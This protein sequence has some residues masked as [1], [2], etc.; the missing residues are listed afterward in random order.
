MANIKI[1]G[2]PLVGSVAA[3]DEYEINQAGTSYK[4]TLSQIRTFVL[5]SAG[6]VTSVA[7]SLPGIFSVSGSPVTT[8]GTLSATLVSQSQNLVFASPNGSAGA[9]TFRSLVSAD[10]PS[11]SSLYAN[12][13]LS[14]LTSPTAI[15]QD[16]LSAVSNTYN[17]GSTVNLWA[18][19]YGTTIVAGN[20][21]LN[22]NGSKTTPSGATSVPSLF[23]V[24]QN[25]KL[26]V[27]SASDANADTIQTGNLYLNTGN[28]TAGTG[29]SGDIEI[30][31]GTSAGGTRGKIRKKDGSEGTAGHVWTSTDTTGGGAWSAPTVISFAA[32]GSTP[33]ANGASIAAGVI[34]LQPASG[35]FPGGVSTTTQTFAGSKTFGAVA[36]DTQTIGAASSTAIHQINGGLK[37]TSRTITAN[38]T[39]DT[40]TTDYLIFCN[41]SGAINVTLPAPTNGRILIIKDI[42]GTANTNNITMVRNAAEKIEGLAASKVL[43]TNFGSWTFTSDG[44]DWWMI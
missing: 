36:A 40:T 43:Q 25:G 35:S 23:T 44:T 30:Y 19:I 18:N 17:F 4:A 28:K 9:P 27:F 14:N 7:L 6:T 22:M 3:S 20:Q 11:L 15:P 21:A 24:F 13:T 1:S 5:A 38:L 32:F 41:Q 37:V 10:I 12:T 8:S 33:N 31:I 34:T 29:N 39:I 16:L 42:S 2:L 26:A